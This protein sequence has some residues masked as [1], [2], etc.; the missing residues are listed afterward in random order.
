MLGGSSCQGVVAED[1][2]CAA[3]MLA[4]NL[5]NIAISEIFVGKVSVLTLRGDYRKA[6]E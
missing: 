4:L 3:V 6:S 2:R 1:R 5:L